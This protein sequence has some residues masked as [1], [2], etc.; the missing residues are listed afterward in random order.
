MIDRNQNKSQKKSKDKYMMDQ[1]KIKEIKSSLKNMISQGMYPQIFSDSKDQRCNSCFSDQEYKNNKLLQCDF[2]QFLTHDKCL[3][4]QRIH[5]IIQ[6]LW[7]CDRCLYII[8]NDFNK[9]NLLDFP[10]ISCSDCNKF[11]GIMINSKNGVWTHEF[12]LKQNRDDISQFS[13]GHSIT[14]NLIQERDDFFQNDESTQNFCQYCRQKE[15]KMSLCSMPGCSKQFHLFCLINENPNQIEQAPLS[16]QKYYCNEHY[17]QELMIT[18]FALQQKQDTQHSSDKNI[19]I[20]QFTDDQQLRNEGQNQI[21]ANQLSKN[22]IQKYKL[23]LRYHFDMINYF[24]QNLSQLSQFEHQNYKQPYS[25]SNINVEADKNSV[26]Q[27]KN[28]QLKI[29]NWEFCF[30]TS[31][32]EFYQNEKQFLECLANYFIRIRSY[33]PISKSVVLF[34]SYYSHSQLLY[35]IRKNFNHP[36]DLLYPENN[37]AYFIDMIKLNVNRFIKELISN[38]II[39]KVKREN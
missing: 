16:K 25:N 14:Q 5:S 17:R 3:S 29:C 6:N 35:F 9:P 21:F 37:M 13:S 10:I 32:P 22:G 8:G 18:N 19:E 30:I 11:H 24:Y 27:D 33:N 12:C 28:C 1:I 38:K 36:N 2:C 34:E 26:N 31:L 20:K 23:Q 15:G 7:F 4:S 39:Q